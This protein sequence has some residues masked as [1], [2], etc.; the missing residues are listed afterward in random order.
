MRKGDFSMR[1]PAYSW[2]GITPVRLVITLHLTAFCKREMKG[3]LGVR[4]V[5]TAISVWGLPL[6]PPPPRPNSSVGRPPPRLPRIRSA[7]SGRSSWSTL[8]F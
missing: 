1:N 8:G 3:S 5:P 4:P 7:E 6:R 2:S